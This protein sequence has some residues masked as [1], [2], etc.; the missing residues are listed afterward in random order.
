MALVAKTTI[1]PDDIGTHLDATVEIEMQDGTRHRRSSREA[2]QV[3]VFQDERRA[4]D[5]FESR[6]SRA[7]IPAAEARRLAADI[8][9]SAGNG[10]SMP[11]RGLLDRLT[12]STKESGT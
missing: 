4:A 9:A 3:L 1:E 12:G 5:V 7:G 2:P 6:L 10:G 11:I 8:L